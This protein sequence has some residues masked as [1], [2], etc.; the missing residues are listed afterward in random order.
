MTTLTKE[1]FARMLHAAADLIEENH[2]A[3]SQLDSATGDGDHG[4]TINRT[5]HA[6]VA[7]L[8]KNAHQP[9]SGLLNAIAMEVMMCDGG[10]TSPLLGSYFLGMASAAKADSMSP[11]QTKI[12]FQAGLANFRK[13]SKAN[14]GDKTMLDAF[15]PAT[16]ALVHEL[17]TSGDHRKAFAVAAARASEGAE[18]TRNFVARFGRARTMGERSVGHLDPGAKSV[19]YIFEGFSKASQPSLTQ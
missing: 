8:E 16:V 13:T 12:M 15:E 9:M 17:S 2:V 4:V 5:M 19:S 14:L 6:V 3:L 11:E 1:Q 18:K 7:A 10:S